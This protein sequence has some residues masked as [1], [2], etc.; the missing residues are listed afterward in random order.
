MSLDVG[1]HAVILGNQAAAKQVIR[2]LLNARFDDN[3]LHE[4]RAVLTKR[5]FDWDAFL[6]E[7]ATEKLMP[8]LYEM[9][10]GRQLLPPMVEATL[11]EAYRY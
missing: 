4:A 10:A 6:A 8:M 5:A 11:K 7:A 3:A 9:L 1:Q 2:T